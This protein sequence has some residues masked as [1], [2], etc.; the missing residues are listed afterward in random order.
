MEK[1]KEWGDAGCLGLIQHLRGN[2][3]ITPYCFVF[4]CSFFGGKFPDMNLEK[5]GSRNCLL[6][7][8]NVWFRK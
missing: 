3:H 2:Q 1:L 5:D 8:V 7:H 4:D 6:G